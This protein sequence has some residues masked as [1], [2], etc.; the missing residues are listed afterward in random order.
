MCQRYY[1]RH[2]FNDNNH[3]YTIGYNYWNYTSTS[4]GIIE[5]PLP[6]AMRSQNPTLI[7]SPPNAS[8]ANLKW[9][10][11]H[12]GGQITC[13]GLID[14]IGIID[15]Y[16]GKV[17]FDFP[18]IAPAGSVYRGSFRLTGGQ[19]MELSYDAEITT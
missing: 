13:A 9:Q 17:A 16:T 15:Y 12:G 8:W 2:A 19:I 1:Q 3:V 11:G 18:T 10:N 5:F 7:A 14:S 6:V 4:V